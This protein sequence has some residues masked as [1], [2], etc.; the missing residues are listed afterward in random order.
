[1]T[2][3]TAQ[4]QQRFFDRDKVIQQ[5][6]RDNV[7][8]LSRMGAFVRR[9]ARTDVLRR[10]PGRRGK[11]GKGER[12]SSPAGQPPLVHSR[13]NHATLRNIQFG[14]G[15]DNASVS[16]GPLFVPSLRPKG[17]SARTIPELLTKGGSARVEQHSFDGEQWQL[18]NLPQAPHH[19]SVN[20][21]YEARPFMS[22]ALDREIKAGTVADVWSAG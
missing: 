3:V 10:A 1:M 9:R 5:L 19:R 7:R 8:K 11:R 18:G 2:T 12:R 6:G 17:S 15:N 14:L 16:I 4:I 20:A 13:S 21:R 22:V